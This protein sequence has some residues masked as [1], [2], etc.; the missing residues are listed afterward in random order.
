MTSSPAHSYASEYPA[1]VDFDPEYKKFFED[2]YKTSDTPDVHDDYVQNFTKT[3]TL[4]RASHPAKG[5]DAILAMRK[6][7]WERI[8]SMV[9]KPVKVFPA[10]NNA[11]ECM[12]RGN[13][14]F[15]LRDGRVSSL[16]WAANAHL[17]KEDG[18]VKMEYYQVFLDTG[19]PIRQPA[20]L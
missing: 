7:Q 12:L 8:Q 10:G 5:H 15:A 11:N 17:V 19:A 13:V 18:R 9:H 20:S 14:E 4:I 16:D 1:G 2:F 6:A 3:A